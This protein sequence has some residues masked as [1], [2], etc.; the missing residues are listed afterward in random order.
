MVGLDDVLAESADRWAA[1]ERRAQGVADRGLGRAVRR[2]FILYLPV[3]VT[4]FFAAGAGLGRLFFPDEAGLSSYSFG[5][6]LAALGIMVGGLVYNAKV[7][8][9]AADMGRIDVTL[10]L[11][12]D[13]KKSVR[14]QVLGKTPATPDHWAVKRAAAVQNRKGLASQLVISPAMLF[15]FVQQATKPENPL[16]WLSATFGALYIIA[17]ILVGR[18][19]RKAGRFLA[20]SPKPHS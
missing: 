8:G 18:D 14:R 9:R 10:S 17:V 11:N 20:T 16:W 7:L 6:L 19:F 12:D 2:Y 5:S 13:E 4:L 15:I 3:G 1:A